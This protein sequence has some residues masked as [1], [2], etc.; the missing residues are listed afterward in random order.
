MYSNFVLRKIGD[1]CSILDPIIIM[2]IM[3]NMDIHLQ[4]F[5]FMFYGTKISYVIIRFLNSFAYELKVAGS[6]RRY[7]NDDHEEYD[8][9]ACFYNLLCTK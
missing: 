8:C 3:R 9:I 6:E 5:S 4:P 2:Y 1:M 7:D